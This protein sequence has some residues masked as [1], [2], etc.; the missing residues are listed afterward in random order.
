MIFS[1]GFLQLNYPDIAWYTLIAFMMFGLTG[2][3]GLEWLLAFR[4]GAAQV[5]ST[6]TE[7]TV[8]KDKTTTTENK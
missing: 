4:G 5:T 2:R 6:T 7:K 3:W 1:S 8:E